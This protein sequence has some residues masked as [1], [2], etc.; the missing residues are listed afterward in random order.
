MAKVSRLIGL[1]LLLLF[2]SASAVFADTVTFTGT[3]AGGPTWNRPVAGNP[4]TPPPS[5]VGTNVPYS[6][7]QLSVGTTGSYTFQS[8]ATN[9]AG[10]DNYTFLYQNSFNPAAQ[11]TN[12]RIGNDDNPIIGLSGFTLN[13]TAGTTYFFIETGFANTDAGQWSTTVTGPGT[14]TIGGGANVPEP[15]TMILLGSGLV[16]IGVKVR[17]RLKAK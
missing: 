12:V 1:F 10:W 5:G 3:T 7:T 13:L 16:G 9:P 2:V 17:K 4:P 8:T 6:V 15:A 14:I 11:F